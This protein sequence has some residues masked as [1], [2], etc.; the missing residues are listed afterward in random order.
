MLLLRHLKPTDHCFPNCCIRN[1]RRQRKTLVGWCYTPTSAWAY[2][3]PWLS[4]VAM[5]DRKEKVSHLS[6]E[7]TLHPYLRV[8]A[9]FILLIFADNCGITRIGTWDLRMTGQTLLHS[10]ASITT[11]L[12]V[13]KCGT[14]SYCYC[15]LLQLHYMLSCVCINL[16]RTVLSKSLFAAL[17]GN[18]FAQTALY[19]CFSK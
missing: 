10:E 3:H 13:R 12:N 14:V 19:F 5:I 2:K 9:N 11:R 7:Y 15:Q 6:I 1:T 4:S 16:L 17:P 8:W 18:S